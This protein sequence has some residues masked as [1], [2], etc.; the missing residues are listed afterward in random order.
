MHNLHEFQ[1]QFTAALQGAPAGPLT[2]PL[3]E[4]LVADGITV[5][6]R[7]DVYRNNV[8]HSLTEAMADAFPVVKRLVGDDFFAAMA[9][10]FLQDHLPARGTLIGFG[11]GFDRF[12]T[13]FEPAQ[14]L[15]YLPDVA[16]L[17]LAWLEAYHSADAD[18]IGADALGGVAPADMAALRLNVHPSARLLS[19]DYPI[20]DIWRTNRDDE[21]VQPVD[22][23]QGGDCLL[24]VRPRLQVEVRRLTPGLGALVGAFIAGEPLAEA[25]DAAL[26]AEPD[27]DLTRGLHDLIAGETFV[28]FE[29]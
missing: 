16:A 15:A 8:F 10:V 18:P 26:G 3:A 28:G 11:A 24:V 1:Q 27:F 17:E 23:T 20:F 14:A 25:A 6:R 7:L 2:G 19:S 4:A 22:L 21:R 13:A 9:R 29:L 5:D 12:L